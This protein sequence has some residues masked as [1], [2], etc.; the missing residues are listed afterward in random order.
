MA[1]IDKSERMLDIYTRFLNGEMINKSKAALKYGVNE[2]SIQRD[3]EEIR[4]FFSQKLIESG[5]KKQ[6]VYD[7]R[8]GGYYLKS[9]NTEELNNGEVLAICKILLDSR[10]LTKKDMDRIL[11]KLLSCCTSHKDFYI[12]KRIIANEAFH[13][14]EPRHKKPVLSQLWELGMAIDE[15]KVIEISYNKRKGGN[16]SRRLQPLAI[17]FSEYYFYLTAFIEDADKS[18]FHVRDDPSPT[19]YRIDRIQSLK[20]TETHFKIPYKNRFEEG[21]FRKRIQFMY[22]GKLQ[23]TV[24]WY[25]GDAIE[26]ILDR[27]PTAQILKEK[28]GK[29][30]VSAETFGSG[31]EMWL[32]SQGEMVE[33]MKES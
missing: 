7:R 8:V 24:F 1:G 20:V 30:L 17:L 15:C 16:V 18:L 32:R 31:I 12:L 10:A 28:D 33:K 13:Y 14:V 29:Y 4:N 22:G 26:A 23:K 11:D 21:E 2:K 6:V 25:K 19:I 9:Q 3:I 5:Q 27:L